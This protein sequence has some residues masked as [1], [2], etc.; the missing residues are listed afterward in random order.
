MEVPPSFPAYLA[1]IVDV[2]KKSLNKL[3]VQKNDA[4]TQ[5]T[6]ISNQINLIVLSIFVSLAVWMNLG[7][8]FVRKIEAFPVFKSMH[9]TEIRD[10]LSVVLI[11]IL[12]PILAFL[13]IEKILQRL[14]KFTIDVVSWVIFAAMILSL[15]WTTNYRGVS[16][17]SLWGG[18]GPGIGLAALVVMLGI[19]LFGNQ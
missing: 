19:Y 6:N 8:F 9:E 17:P 16:N 2:S 14:D 15:G 18:F 11:C 13:N 12:I 7:I 10:R 1:T 5:R 4:I 3:A